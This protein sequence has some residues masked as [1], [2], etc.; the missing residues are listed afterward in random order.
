MRLLHARKNIPLRSLSNSVTCVNIKCL[1]PIITEAVAMAYYKQIN[2]ECRSPFT[3]LDFSSF[4]SDM[5]L[6]IKWQL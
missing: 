5:V 1:V 2:G 4:P 6:R 3:R